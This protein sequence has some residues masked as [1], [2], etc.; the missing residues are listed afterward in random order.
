MINLLPPD[1]KQHY[2]YARRNTILR[3]WITAFVY[4]LLGIVA[5]TAFGIFYMQQSANTFRQ[6]VAASQNM[7]DSQKLDS[8]RSQADDIT[9]NLKLVVQVLS[10]EILFSQLLK[11]IATVTPSNAALTD[12]SISKVQGAIDIT[13]VADNYNTATQLQVNLQ[14]PANKIFSK[15]DIQNINCAAVNAEDPHYPCTII[16]RALFSQ[17][18][19]YLFINTGA[20][21]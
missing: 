5:I 6:Q 11:Q 10:R 18:N 19:P 21:K 17:N 14:D 12:L 8:V 3:H 9:T 13:A 7:L 4:G 2:I 1:V 20:K 15:A 16:I